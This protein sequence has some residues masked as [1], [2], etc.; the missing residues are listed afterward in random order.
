MISFHY[1]LNCRPNKQGR[2][3][4]FLRIT[5]TD[6]KKLKRVKTTIELSRP[7]DWNKK[8]ERVRICERNAEAWNNVLDNNLEEAKR[9]Y[10]SLSAEGLAT[11]NQIAGRIKGTS[12]KQTLL[13]YSK[14]YLDTIKQ[15]GR[16]GSWQKYGNTIK[17]LEAFLTDK[18]GSVND[19][20]FA[21][22]T[23]N[24]IENFAAYLR[25]H[26]N[27]KHPGGTLH[28]NTIA[29]HLRCLRAIINKA[30]TERL[31][32]PEDSPFRS[33][34]ISELK[35]VKAKL[36]I[37]EIHAL[38]EVELAEGSRPWHA[39]NAFL[40][41]YYCAGIRAGDV[42]QLRWNNITPEGR[43]CYRMGKN[44]KL[45]D[46]VL[47]PQA[48]AIL[49]KYATE[50]TK[51]GSYIFPYLDSRA[52]YARYATEAEKAM[53]P[54]PLKEKLFKDVNA[55]EVSLNYQ[56]RK[57]AAAAGIEK[58]ISFH[59]SRHSFAKQAKLAGTD[60][61]L[62]KDLMAHS[63]LATTERYMKDFDTSL[64]DQ[65]LVKIFE[66][67]AGE[68]ALLKALR[69]LNKEELASLLSKLQ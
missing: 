48:K 18:Y 32:K 3:V 38:E 60:N 30:I 6:T 52:K 31:M 69:N 27:A 59:I 8:Q 65:A 12:K 67:G 44:G 53:M 36:T 58:H 49:E 7:S 10:R 25:Q 34:K 20:I 46:V 61:E 28:P 54:L 2:Y 14:Q 21:E 47:V 55:R 68:D 24:F 1:E 62:L 4:V 26:P 37:D 57:A 19:V 39:K 45:K 51:P 13:A 5:D 56:L 22:V 41:S 42:I 40:L 17:N 50:G 33:Y 29:K 15:E 63:S 64:E 66:E 16:L 11:A 9:T 43:L 23:L 35:G